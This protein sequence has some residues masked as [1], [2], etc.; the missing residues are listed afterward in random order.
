MRQLALVV[1]VLQRQA[2]QTNVPH[3]TLDNLVLVL[4]LLFQLLSPY[5][6]PLLLRPDNIPLCG[7]HLSLK[8]HTLMLLHH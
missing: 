7:L 8:A 3:N 2:L 4:L 5:L 6:R 1:L